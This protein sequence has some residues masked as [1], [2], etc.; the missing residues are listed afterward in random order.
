MKQFRVHFE[1][2][3][4]KM[5]TTISATNPAAAK[6]AVIDKIKFHKVERIGL[7]IMDFLNG[8]KR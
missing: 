2:Y 8:F 4:R 5:K 6:R 3:G 7:D 1:M